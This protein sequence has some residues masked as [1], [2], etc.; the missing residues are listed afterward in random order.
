MLLYFLGSEVMS[1]KIKC[2]KLNEKNCGEHCCMVM[3]PVSKTGVIVGR[4]GILFSSDGT[5]S[6]LNDPRRKLFPYSEVPTH[7]EKRF[8]YDLQLYSNQIFDFDNLYS[9]LENDKCTN[10]FPFQKNKGGILVRDNFYTYAND[11]A[12]YSMSRDD[13]LESLKSTDDEDR[14]IIL[15]GKNCSDEIIIP[16]IDE[17]VER[18]IKF[19][20]SELDLCYQRYFTTSDETDYSYI[21]YRICNKIN[22]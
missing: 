15:G 4:E 13:L 16:K 21:A 10:Y 19:L 9:V 12:V 6:Y 7:L 17:T 20:K 14:I 8:P 5:N 1:N 18:T 11:T 2:F 22:K 3:V